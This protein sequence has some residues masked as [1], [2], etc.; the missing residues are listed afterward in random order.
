MVLSWFTS[1]LLSMLCAAVMYTLIQ[2]YIL[3]LGVERSFDRSMKVLPVM[4][5]L[6]AFVIALFVVYKGAKGVGMHKTDLGLAIAIS[7][8]VGGV[9]GLL[10][11]PMANHIKKR[12]E[13]QYEVDAAK[14]LEMGE[15]AKEG[16]VD[17]ARG[18]REGG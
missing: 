12:L 17:A 7:L 9:L 6:T 14:A 11:L 16:R 2:K 13:L 4:I 3:N 18:G 1:P 8:V 5:F 10:S 15:V